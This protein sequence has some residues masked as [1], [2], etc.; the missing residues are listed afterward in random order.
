MTASKNGNGVAGNGKKK[1]VA[2]LVLEQVRRVA[3]D[4][5]AGLTLDTPITEIGLDS[6]ER[7][8]ILASLEER[9]GGRF[10][11]DV[12][13]DLETC[14]EVVEAVEKYL[15]KEPRP[16]ASSPINAEIP[17]DYYRLE[18]FPEYVKLRQ[19]LDL[20][21]MSGLSNP[22]F[23]VHEDHQRPHHD[24][25][26]GVHQLFELQLRGHVGRPGGHQSRPGR[27]RPLW[28]ERFR[29]P[30]GLG[31]KRHPR[32]PGT[33]DRRFRGRRRF[34]RPGWRHSTSR[35]L[36]ATWSARAT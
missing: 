12:L 33:D 20:L 9:F 16:I 15:G 6:L 1:S 11:P 17:E 21:N 14:R 22:Y 26:S 36:S 7:M 35:A 23:T 8:E 4:R 28:N 3:R 32:D 34:H 19:N 13:P 18:R 24:R 10:P 29:Q 2:D 25:W 31:P 30:P 27:R 5:A